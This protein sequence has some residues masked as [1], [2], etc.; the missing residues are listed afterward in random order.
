[1]QPALINLICPRCNT[2]HAE[3][4]FTPF[5]LPFSLGPFART[6]WALCPKTGEPIIVN[7]LD[8][9]DAIRNIAWR[10]DDFGE[11]W[12]ADLMRCGKHV[13]RIG[14]YYELGENHLRTSRR[15]Q[16]LELAERFEIES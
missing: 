16:E 10:A 9:K 7:V 15:E 12:V 1:M 5:K 13:G 11:Y 8:D 4:E 3:L 6:H 14:T 2:P